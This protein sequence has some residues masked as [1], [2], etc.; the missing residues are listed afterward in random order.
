MCIQSCIC[1][2]RH[3]QC[4]TLPISR[5]DTCSGGCACTVVHIYI[6]KREYAYFSDY[7]STT[8]YIFVPYAEYMYTATDMYIQCI[9]CKDSS[10]W[11][12]RCCDPPL[13]FEMVTRFP[14][15][16]ADCKVRLERFKCVSNWENKTIT[17]FVFIKRSHK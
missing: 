14:W 12:F 6:N 5:I 2:R 13:N 3:I 11:L 17:Q 4:I 1:G 15:Q 8:L 16:C 9:L 10:V 7:R